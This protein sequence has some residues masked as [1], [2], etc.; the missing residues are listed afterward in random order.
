MAGT[1]LDGLAVT[2]ARLE[3]G[4]PNNQIGGFGSAIAY[5]GVGD[6]YVT[7][8][9]RGPNAGAD[10]YVERAYL[11]ELSLAGG[12]VTP[13]FR[14]GAILRNEAGQTLIGRD[15]AFDAT[16]SP[17]SRRFDSEGVRVSPAGTFYVSDEYGPFLYEFGP[18]GT[19]RRALSS[20]WR[21]V[22]ASSRSSL[23]SVRL[24]RRWRKRSGNGA[25]LA[26]RS[27]SSPRSR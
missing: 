23:P 9:D 18:D 3:D 26:G 11:L 19:R 21:R 5:T 6:L 16:N 10:S 20:H 2:P 13:A 25:S 12:T 7:T 22:C 1:A 15:T 4:V 17:A 27:A 24:G 8:P 14:G